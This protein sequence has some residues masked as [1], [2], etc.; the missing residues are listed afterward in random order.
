M[1]TFHLVIGVALIIFLAVVALA[2]ALTNPSGALVVLLL[3]GAMVLLAFLSK[4]KGTVRE[5]IHSETQMNTSKAAPKRVAAPRSE[6]YSQNLNGGNWAITAVLSREVASIV[7]TQM[8]RLNALA[9]G[10]RAQFCQELAGSVQIQDGLMMADIAKILH[11]VPTGSS[12]VALRK[13]RGTV[14]AGLVV[15]AG[16]LALT[17]EGFRRGAL[18]PDH[19]PGMWKL[20]PESKLNLLAEFTDSPPESAL[21]FFVLTPTGGCVM[22]FSHIVRTDNDVQWVSKADYT[23]KVAKV[24][25][26]VGLFEKG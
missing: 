20:I 9:Q 8:D 4:R 7:A 19:S 26:D 1:K 23:E 12:I 15:A 16:D 5:E 25:L 14:L 17:F 2:G 21:A 18:N 22:A 24:L 3:I 6:E 10:N 13:Y 11:K